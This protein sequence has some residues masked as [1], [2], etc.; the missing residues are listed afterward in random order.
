MS[1]LVLIEFIWKLSFSIA[2]C[3]ESGGTNAVKYQIS[4]SNVCYML[5]L[6]RWNSNH[7]AYSNICGLEVSNEDFS[8]SLDDYVDFVCA[9]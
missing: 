6:S 9:L 1:V 4:L 7:I 8:C 3:G 5:R 2:F